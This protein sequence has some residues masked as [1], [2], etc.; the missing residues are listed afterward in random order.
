MAQEQLA[1]EIVESRPIVAETNDPA[2]RRIL[3]NIDELGLTSNLL[4]LLVQGFT[5]VPGVLSEDRI[6]RAKAAMVRRAEKVA[7]G[8]VDPD[9]AT[10]KDF[11]GLQ[12]LHYMLF[13][14]PVFPEIMLEPKPLA[15]VTYLL[16][17]NCLLSSMG[18]HFRGPGGMPLPVHVDGMPDE[19]LGPTALIANC[20]YALTPYTQENGALV[21]FPGSHRKNRQPTAPE[22]WTSGG[23]T[24]MEIMA[25]QPTPEEID[26]IEWQVPHG[27]VTME[28]NP[29]DAAIW[30]GNSWHGGWRRDVPGARINLAAYFCRDGITTQE[31]RKD[32]NHP[33]VFELYKDEPRFAQ[34][35]GENAFNGWRD[36]G[37]N[38]P[39]R[40]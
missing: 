22:N 29:G 9:S 28:L 37:P 31:L 17:E 15:L 35:M 1:S 26:K 10:A 14:D 34:L 5:V 2:M 11:N 6:E 13:D 20:N 25:E 16:G 7:K 30:H 12:Y 18:C 23:K 40:V 36:E 24:I 39:G 4:D 19:C 38:L 8:A 21:L 32:R 33:E 27:G 3:D